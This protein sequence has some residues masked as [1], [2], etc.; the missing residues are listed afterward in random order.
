M[1][2]LHLYL[3]AR[4][5]HQIPLWMVWATMW[6]LRIELMNSGGAA[7]L[8][9]VEPSL[10]LQ[11]FFIWRFHT[12]IQYILMALPSPSP[13][14]SPGTHTEKRVDKHTRCPLQVLSFPVWHSFL[15]LPVQPFCILTAFP[16]GKCLAQE[17]DLKYFVIKIED[18][19]PGPPRSFV[20]W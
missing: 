3:H 10:Q 20:F 6:L 9:T 16:C 15:T 7:S 8:L 4:R 11:H 14:H 2:Y 12:W 19:F 5:G 18:S 17:T 13:P 1:L